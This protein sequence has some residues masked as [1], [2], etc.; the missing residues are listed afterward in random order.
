MKEFKDSL[1][2]IFQKMRSWANKVDVSLNAFSLLRLN[3][4]FGTYQFTIL[5]NYHFLKKE[6]FAPRY[7]DLG[8]VAMQL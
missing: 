7:F 8:V 3:V 5:V 4:F 6:I 1:T 2:Q